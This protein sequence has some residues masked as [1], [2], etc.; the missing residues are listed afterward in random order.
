MAAGDLFR[1]YLAKV[2]R[3]PSAGL[4]RNKSHCLV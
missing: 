3:R 1:Q 2:Y 4:V